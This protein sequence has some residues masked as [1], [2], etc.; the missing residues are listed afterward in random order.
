L[1]QHPE[2]GWSEG[3]FTVKYAV[4]YEKTENNYAAYIPD[5]PGCVATGKT[6]EEVRREIQE[7][8]AF[9]IEGLKADGLK[10]PPPQ[11][12]CDYVEAA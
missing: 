5:L 4:V 9:H 3:R 2:A 10:V 11:S 6:F 8:M 12:L 1:E 7:A